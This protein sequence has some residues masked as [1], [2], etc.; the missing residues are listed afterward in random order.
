[1]LKG[2]ENLPHRPNIS[3][4]LFK[5]GHF[6]LVQKP[7]WEEDWWKFPQGGIDEGENLDSAAIRE[8]KE[9]V[10]TDSVE[11]LGISKHVNTYDWPDEVLERLKYKKFRGQSQRFF[12]ARFI[13]SDDEIK[14]DEKEISK[15]AWFSRDEIIRLS[16]ERVGT[17][18]DYQGIIPLVLEEFGI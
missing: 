10:G 14:P 17:F 8:L 18:R 13:G 4:I 1:M 11:V 12:V 9:E 3:I 2:F 6:L 15:V 16:E 7:N 5:D